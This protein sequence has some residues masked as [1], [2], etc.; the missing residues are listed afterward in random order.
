MKASY[1]ISMIG[2]LLVMLLCTSA[3]VNGKSIFKPAGK[4]VEKD[5]VL[6]DFNKIDN[7]SLVNVVYTQ[8]SA[9]AKLTAPEDI[10]PLIYITNEKGVLKIQID[11]RYKI[12]VKNSPTLTISSAQLNTVTSLG[13]GDIQLSKIKGDNL[14]V[15]LKGSG[16]FSIDKVVLNK[17]TF[18]SLGSGDATI[19]S[20]SSQTLNLSTQGSGDCRIR[21]YR[22]DSIIGKSVGSGD[23]ILADVDAKII[24]ILSKGSGDTDLSGKCDNL[25]IKSNGSGDFNIADLKYNS[26]NSDIKGAG[27]LIK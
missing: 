8:G 3:C 5:L 18:N 10:I 7:R 19:T 13:S 26:L 20:S 15:Q 21:N 4:T 27:D 11:N 12:L 17:L 9:S 6:G 14:D 23:F 1:K 2:A 22:A 24:D 25:T 16:D